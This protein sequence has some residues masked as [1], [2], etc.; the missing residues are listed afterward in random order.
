M[1]ESNWICT[2]TGRRFYPTA[3]RAQDVDIVDIAHALSN[4]CRYTGHC[5]EFYSVAQHSFCVARVVLKSFGADLVTIRAAL[6]HDA[7]EAYTNDIARPLKVSLPRYKEIEAAVQQAIYERF[8]VVNFDYAAIKKADNA[9]LA[10]EAK[11]LMVNTV[12]WCLPEPAPDY[13]KIVPLP[14]A[15]AKC[16]FEDTW[17]YLF[18][19]CG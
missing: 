19:D 2:Y 9:V 1:S 15:S 13:L 3:P 6:L 17:Q 11:T 10:A 4:L 14:P 8:G 5:R 18:E 16:V 7:A 12:D